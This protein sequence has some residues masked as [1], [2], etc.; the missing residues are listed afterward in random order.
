M[1]SKSSTTLR[2]EM[3]ADKG[4]TQE[5]KTVILNTLNNM[6]TTAAD[7]AV[8][9]AICDVIIAECTQRALDL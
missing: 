1:A 5:L 9:D 8:I 6:S 7:L 4:Q 2:A 3:P